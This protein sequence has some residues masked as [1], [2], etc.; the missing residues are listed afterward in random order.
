[1]A[2]VRAQADTAIAAFLPILAAKQAA[3]LARTGGRSYWQ[4]LETHVATPTGGADASPDLTRKPRDQSESWADEGYVVPSRSFSFQV[5]VYS[6]KRWR[7][8]E[9]VCRFRD[10]G[11]TW[12][13]VVNVGPEDYREQPWTF[14]AEP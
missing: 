12:Q 10:A 13:R 4:G 1:M 3:Y 8:Y 14:L 6:L 7:G 2:D 5:N 9:L 11:G